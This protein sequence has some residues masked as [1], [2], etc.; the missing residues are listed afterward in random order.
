MPL[1]SQGD[2]LG[3]IITDLCRQSAI[4]VAEGDIFVLAQKIV[5]KSEGR[6]VNLTQ[7]DASPAAI[8]LAQETGKDPRFVEL[9]LR[10]SKSV[11]RKRAGV[12]I[13][14]HNLGFICANAGI[15][16]SNVKGSWGDPDDWVLLLPENPDRS[17]DTIRSRLQA[18]FG[19]R[20]GVL[21]IDSHG[22]AWRIGTVG[23]A[24]GISGIPGLVDLRGKEDLFGY[25]LQITQVAAAD[26]LAA[27]ASLMMGQAAE[28]SP[29]VH[30]RGFPYPLRESAL[31]ELIR[32]LDEDLFR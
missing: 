26:E 6:L 21:V 31:G 23:V 13:V 4:Q 10:E 20:L 1:V 22:R 24:I 12:L 11:L 17:A 9:V 16:H 5:S 30:V 7:I 19:F 29:V 8:Q 18:L 15:D 28:A 25:R 27:A 3:M 2:D 32:P 14:E